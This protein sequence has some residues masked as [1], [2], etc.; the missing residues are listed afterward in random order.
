[1]STKFN[2]KCTTTLYYPDQVTWHILGHVTYPGSRDIFSASHMTEADHVTCRTLYTVLGHVT[3]VSWVTWHI[4]HKA[5]DICWSCHRTYHN[6]ESVDPCG[7]DF[8]SRRCERRQRERRGTCSTFLYH[9][10]PI[11]QWWR[12]QATGQEPDW[13]SVKGHANR[14]D[15]VRVRNKRGRNKQYLQIFCKLNKYCIFLKPIWLQVK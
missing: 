11:Y 6:Q 1:M 10:F 12:G 5:H 4:L 9:T 7:P 14:A 2:V 8:R 15:S 13:R 3:Y